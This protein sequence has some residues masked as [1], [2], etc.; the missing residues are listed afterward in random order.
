MTKTITQAVWQTLQ[1]ELPRDALITDPVELIAYEIDGSLGVGQPHG[2]ALPRNIDEVLTVVKW[3][4]ENGI[5]V[6]ARGAGTGL[7]GGAIS[8]QGGVMISF[9]RMKQILELDEAGRSAVVESGVIH[10][11]F[12][13]FTRGEVLVVDGAPDEEFLH[14]QG[15]G[16]RKL[17]DLIILDRSNLHPGVYVM[18]L[19]TGEW[20]RVSKVDECLWVTAGKNGP[21]RSPSEF[22][23]AVSD[24]A[25][26]EPFVKCVLADGEPDLT[27]GH[28]YRLAREGGDRVTVANDRGNEVSYL[29][30]RFS[31]DF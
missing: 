25:L 30:E 14:V 24:G 19:S 2:V 15:I 29:A 5:P 26:V 27:L 1:A 21:F 16:N 7:S 23:F 9:A 10:L 4:A 31:M 18:D 3:A 22:K 11:T 13:E 17:S 8:P 20:L 12:D 28:L 6:V